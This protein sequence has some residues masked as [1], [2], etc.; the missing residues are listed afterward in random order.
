MVASPI[1]EGTLEELY[2]RRDEFAGMRLAVF[3]APE[4]ELNLPTPPT[5]IRDQAHLEEMLIAGVN[6]PKKKVTEATWE[7]IRQEVRCRPDRQ[8]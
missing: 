8:A 2:R 6:S 4:A 1:F 7:H 3:A 5:T